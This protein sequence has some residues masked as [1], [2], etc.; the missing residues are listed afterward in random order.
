MDSDPFLDYL[1]GSA[2]GLQLV[3]VVSVVSMLVL[4][5]SLS[6]VEPGSRTYV[7][8]V[9]QH[10]SFAGLFVLTGTTLL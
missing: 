1:C 3:F 5:A 7:L 4:G 10:V 8:A 9:F 6:V 2:R